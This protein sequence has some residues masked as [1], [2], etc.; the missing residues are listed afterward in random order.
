MGASKPYSTGIATPDFQAV[1]ATQVAVRRPA[2]K[3]KRG[4]GLVHLG[5]SALLTDDPAQPLSHFG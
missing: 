5:K 2:H 3:A 4:T 1:L